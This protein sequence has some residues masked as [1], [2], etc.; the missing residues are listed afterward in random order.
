MTIPVPLRRL[1]VFA[2]MAW[3]IAAVEPKSVAIS[4]ACMP[5]DTFALNILGRL[6]QLVMT[7]DSIKVAA[8]QRMQLGTPPVGQVSNV[9]NNSTCNSVAVAYNA[10]V[11]RSPPATPSPAIYVWQVGSNYVAMDTAETVGEFRVWMTLTKKFAVVTKYN[12]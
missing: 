11:T 7:T 4:T 10:A 6:K 3:T 8:R 9:T 5:V 2:G 1:V 12:F